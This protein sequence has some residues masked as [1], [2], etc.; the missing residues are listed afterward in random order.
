MTNIV[1]CLVIG[2]LA[3]ILSGLLGIGGGLLMV[4]AFI[5]LFGLSAHMAQ[6]TALTIMLP[7]IGILAVL[8]YYKNGNVDFR[9]AAFACLGFVLGGLFG[10]KLANILQADTLKRVFGII[11]MLVSIRMIFGR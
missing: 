2:L 6:G 7:P 3:G 11:M 4:P 1:L 5:Y 10:A 9:I 8:T